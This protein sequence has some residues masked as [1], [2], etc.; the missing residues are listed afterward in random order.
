MGCFSWRKK[1]MVKWGVFFPGKNTVGGYLEY[2]I[3]YSL[4]LYWKSFPEKRNVVLY[5]LTTH[6]VKEITDPLGNNDAQHER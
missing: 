6:L 1:T 4:N 3:A 2:L 5:Y